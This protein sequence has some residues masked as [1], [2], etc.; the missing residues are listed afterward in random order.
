MN[1]LV[2]RL[3][4]ISHALSSLC[5]SLKNEGELKE[6]VRIFLALPDKNFWLIT[7]GAPPESCDSKEASVSLSVEVLSADSKQRFLD[8]SA[9]PQVEVL[10]GS[11]KVAGS[12]VVLSLFSQACFSD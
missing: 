7:P 2:S 11:W 9:N 10:E 4:Y 6:D 1:D 3:S 8:G 5:D 12:S